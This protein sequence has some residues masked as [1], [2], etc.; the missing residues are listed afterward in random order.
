MQSAQ[1]NKINVALWKTRGGVLTTSNDTNT[2]SPGTQTAADNVNTLNSFNST[3][4]G[5]V[6]G[7][8]TSNAVLGYAVKNGSGSTIETAQMK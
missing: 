3:S 7:N 8:G 5:F 1:Y 6:Y 4:Y 2:F